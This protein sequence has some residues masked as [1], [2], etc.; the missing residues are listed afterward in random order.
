M[1]QFVSLLPSTEEIIRFKDRLAEYSLDSF[2]Q[3]SNIKKPFTLKKLSRPE[4]FII[5]ILKNETVI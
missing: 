2:E 3:L 4:E 5:K 1:A